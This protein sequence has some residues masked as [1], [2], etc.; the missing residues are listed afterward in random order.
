ML[1]RRN[2]GRWKMIEINALGKTVVCF[3][4]DANAPSRYVRDHN[5]SLAWLE[6][7]LTIRI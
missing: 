1:E 3:I 7:S 4:P 6:T 2:I 5:T